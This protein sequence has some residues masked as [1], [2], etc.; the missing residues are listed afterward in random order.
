MKPQLLK[1][2]DNDK[3]AKPLRLIKSFLEG[4][5]NNKRVFQYHD[6]LYIL[7]IIYSKLIN[8][9]HN[10]L[11]ERHFGIN[12]IQEL[13]IRKY[14]WPTFRYNMKSYVKG[15]NVYLA[16]KTIYHKPYGDLQL[17]PVL[18]YYLNDLLIDFVTG[19]LLFAN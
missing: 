7:K 19:F 3:E 9:H 10:D 13:I 12:K 6:L 15:C 1:L 14:Y 18:I 4:L 2:Q 17:L 11:L 16:S 8:C 5:E